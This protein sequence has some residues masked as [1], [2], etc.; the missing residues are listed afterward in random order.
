MQPLTYS[1]DYVVAEAWFTPPSAQ[2]SVTYTEV[3]RDLVTVYPA[4]P[5]VSDCTWLYGNIWLMKISCQAGSQSMASYCRVIIART[6]V[7]P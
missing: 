4:K 2:K 1:V 6:T 3:Q 5:H 7:K